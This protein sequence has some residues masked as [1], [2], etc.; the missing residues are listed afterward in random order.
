[1]KTVN[2]LYILLFGL[3][4]YSQESSSLFYKELFDFYI[5][6]NTE[7]NIIYLFEDAEY[8]IVSKEGFLGQYYQED[9]L[10]SV[11]LTPLFSTGD[12]HNV[13]VIPYHFTGLLSLEQFISSLYI[14]NYEKG[15]RIS[16]HYVG[17]PIEDD[18]WLSYLNN[19]RQDCKKI[20]Y[21]GYYYSMLDEDIQGQS[22]IYK[23]KFRDEKIVK[24]RRKLTL[25]SWFRFNF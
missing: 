8:K 18:N 7:K 4:G 11:D 14:K 24:V 13:L 2:I 16:F 5:E 22:I 6:K 15:E 12:N 21:H 10:T 25:S 3:I 17:R 20:M 23:C 1:M 19:E 9:S